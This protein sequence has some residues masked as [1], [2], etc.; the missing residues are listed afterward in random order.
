[1]GCRSVCSVLLLLSTAVR[2]W[3]TG[4]HAAAAYV[5]TDI[6][7]A[8]AG[9]SSPKPLALVLLALGLAGLLIGNTRRF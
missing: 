6:A 5:H 7:C 2:S 8:S 4:I 3:P 1:M 9:G